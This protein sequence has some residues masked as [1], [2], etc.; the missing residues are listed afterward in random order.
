MKDSYLFRYFLLEL[1]LT[2]SLWSIANF[3]G[4]GLTHDSEYYLNLSRGDHE[5]MWRAQG[6]LP[7]I[8]SM[9]HEPET[10]ARWINFASLICTLLIWMRIVHRSELDIWGK[11][12]AFSWICLSLPFLAVTSFLWTEPLFIVISSTVFLFLQVWSKRKVLLESLLLIPLLILAVW[13]RKIGLVLA[14]S[15]AIYVASCFMDSKSHRHLL[16]LVSA[17]LLLSGWLFIFNGERPEPQFIAQNLIFNVNALINWFLP[18][19]VPQSLRV[20]FG[21]SFAIF[22]IFSQQSSEL[23]RFFWIYFVIY[24]L[25]RLPI[26]REFAEEADRYFAIMHAPFFFILAHHLKFVLPQKTIIKRMVN[27]TI[28]F[29]IVISLF[30][31]SFSAFRWQQSRA[32]QQS[33][34]KS[35]ATLQ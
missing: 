25:V 12:F 10:A 29:L 26:E 31:M 21:T 14:C 19:S 30:R 7:L 1:V 15:V 11:F 22:F 23:S 24:F 8:L 20:L 13:A 6:L 4:L 28:A 2:L 33:P 3:H 34:N 27:L 17:C 9:S 18:T 35:S 32:V 5:L 16:Y